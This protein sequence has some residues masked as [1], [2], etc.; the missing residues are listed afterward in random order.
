MKRR[1]FNIILLLTSFC[2]ML[3]VS[4]GWWIDGF[5]SDSFI[6][7]SANISSEI[8][9]YKGLDFN[10]DGNLDKVENP[11]IIVNKTDK[12]V[13]KKVLVLDFGTTLP[14]EVHTWKIIVKNNGDAAGY[15][16]ATLSTKLPDDQLK[17]VK[18][19][20]VSAVYNNIN[21]IHYLT[22]VDDT[23]K[24]NG[25]MEKAISNTGT[26]TGAQFTYN[27]IAYDIYVKDDIEYF[28]APESTYKEKVYLYN[29]TETTALFGN[30]DLDIVGIGKTKEYVFQIQLEAFEDLI[31]AGICTDADKEEYQELQSSSSDT[32]FEFLDVS[33]S[34]E[35]LAPNAGTNTN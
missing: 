21:C 32:T 17:L 28:I 15:V 34:G 1:M 13:D 18:Y 3:S 4:F 20:S 12:T 2:L 14:T 10:L 16:Y 26:L 5:V 6:I 11:F 9:L 24:F 8:T 31:A 7:K 27:G 33:L 23:K 29:A 35:V 30:T 19:M 22:N 25:K